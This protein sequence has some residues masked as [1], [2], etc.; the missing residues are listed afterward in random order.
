MRHCSAVLCKIVPQYCF[1]GFSSHGADRYSV[2]LVKFDEV[3]SEFQ[4]KQIQS[5]RLPRGTATYAYN[6]TVLGIQVEFCAFSM[7]LTFCACI[8]LVSVHYMFLIYSYIKRGYCQLR[9]RRALSLFNNVALRTR[10]VLS[11]YNVY[12]DSALLVLNG[13]LLNSINALLVLSRR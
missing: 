6:V 3:E 2:L 7:F 10:R 13:T 8:M 12:G 1:Q 5:I 4:G 9:A 11:L